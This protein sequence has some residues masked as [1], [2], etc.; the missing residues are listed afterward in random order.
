[1]NV[2][3]ERIEESDAG[4]VIR[5]RRMIPATWRGAMNV[6]SE[7]IEESDAGGVIRSRPADMARR[8]PPRRR[9]THSAHSP[10]STAQAIRHRP[11]RL[12]L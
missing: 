11:E 7:R 8:N 12:R 5:S 10:I 1:M 4:G 6:E 2:E 9:R 3:F